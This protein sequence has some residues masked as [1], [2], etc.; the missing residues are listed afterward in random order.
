M[1]GFDF[2]T[3]TRAVDHRIA[4]LRKALGDE[5]GEPRFIATVAGAGYRFDG[6]VKAG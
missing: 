1:W 2:P 6:E 3:G 4:E 5:V